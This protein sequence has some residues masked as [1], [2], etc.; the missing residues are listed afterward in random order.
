MILEEKTAPVIRPWDGEENIPVTEWGRDHWSTLG[1]VEIRCVYY[2]GKLNNDRMRTYA[3][4]HRKLLGDTGL[5]LTKL[6]S[7]GVDGLSDPLSR[8]RSPPEARRLGLPQ[9]RCSGWL[10][11]NS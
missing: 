10:R 9:R 8:R 3:R 4:R 2:G 6:R 5:R 11:R 1:Y 7:G